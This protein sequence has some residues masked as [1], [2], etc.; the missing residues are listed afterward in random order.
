[1]TN[2]DLR[3]VDATRPPGRFARVYAAIA[4]TSAAGFISRH[5]NWKLD[6]FLLRLTGGRLATTLVF[7][8]QLLET[9]GARSGITRRNA[10]IYFHDGETV[11][12]VASNAGSPQHPAWFHNLC[13]HPEVTFGGRPMRAAVIE[14]EAERSRLWP[15][16]DNVFPAYASYRRAATSAARTIPIIGL[17]PAN[18]MPSK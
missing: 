7:P 9:R 1:M 5:L 8:T 10:V 18:P 14:D 13:A 15:L 16:A 17:T 12:I 2:D 11:V 6:P 3:R 4:A